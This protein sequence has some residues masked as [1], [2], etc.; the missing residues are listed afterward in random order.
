MP[1]ELVAKLGTVL[2][3]LTSGPM[4]IWDYY[5]VGWFKP[6]WTHP[7]IVRFHL[8]DGKITVLCAKGVLYH[9]ERPEALH[10]ITVYHDLSVK[11]LN[12]KL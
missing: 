5:R 3:P 12:W 4:L 2:G 10:G 9:P 1:K 11:Q 6:D 7:M 8:A